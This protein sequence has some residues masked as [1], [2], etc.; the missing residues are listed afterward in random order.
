ME[1]KTFDELIEKLG[2]ITQRDIHRIAYETE[3]VCED[4]DNE[5]PPFFGKVKE[6]DQNGGEGEGENWDVVYHFVH[7]DVYM[8]V[9]GSYY[10]HDGT[11]FDDGL[12][13]A[14]EVRPK[15]KTITVYE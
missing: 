8:K 15:E 11:Y 1:K 14:T 5:N 12:K 6:V 9:E 3:S 13:S 10:S 7:H 2:E 4:Y